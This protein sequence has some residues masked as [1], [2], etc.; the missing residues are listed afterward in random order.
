MVVGRGGFV[1]SG[2]SIWGRCGQGQGRWGRG[3]EFGFRHSILFCF[4]LFFRAAPAA[5]GGSRLGGESE[6]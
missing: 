3:H 1:F 6:L 5:Y 2:L 4:V